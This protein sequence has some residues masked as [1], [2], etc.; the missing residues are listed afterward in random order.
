MQPVVSVKDL[1]TILGGR[2]IHDGLSFHVNKGEIFGI[3]G[4]SGSGKSTVLRAITLLGKFQK[5]DI[6]ILGKSLKNITDE[7]SDMLRLKWGVLFQSGALF[8]SLSVAENIAI[9]L[10][11]HTNLSDDLIEEIIKLKIRMVGLPDYSAN[12]YPR[13][14]SGGMKKRASLARALAMDPKI[15]FLDEPTSGLDPIGARAFDELIVNLR[16]ML[17]LTVIMITH[18]PD[19]IQNILDRMV[20]ISDGKALIEGTLNEVKSSNNPSISR[21]FDNIDYNNK[22]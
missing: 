3:L 4:G 8:T 17:G 16:D 14:L 1:V 12:L 10:K 18:D 9:V 19:S 11:E 2:I 13:E 15:L 21:F 7:D 22:V 5:G 6:E 20:I